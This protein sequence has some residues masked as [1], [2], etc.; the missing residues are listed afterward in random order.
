MKL[1]KSPVVLILSLLASGNVYSTEWVKEIA[2]EGAAKPSLA[3]GADNQPRIAFM[4]EAMPGFVGFAERR[5][6]MWVAQQVASGYFYGPLDL[7]MRG[8]SPIINY[9]DHD[10]EDQVVAIRDE[11]GWSLNP[12]NHPGHDGWDNT[13]AIDSAGRLHTLTT[14]PLDF[15]GPGLEYATLEGGEWRVEEVGTGPIMYAEGLSM[16][17]A[18]DSAPHISYHNTLERSLYYG[19]RLEGGWQLTRVDSGP[20]AGMFSSI[21]LATD[22]TPHI[23]YVRFTVAGAEI[24]LATLQDGQWRSELV[25][26]LPDLT[27]GF[28]FARNATSLRIDPAGFR[29]VAY[30]GESTINLA[31][32]AEAGWEIEIIDTIANNLGTRFG[33]Q[34]DLERD[35]MGQ[36]HLVTFEVLNVSPLT[37]NILYYRSVP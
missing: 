15:G 32:K 23:S 27:V 5:D 19:T 2:F 3:I 18:G 24:C 35:A 31:R 37:G 12:I 36:W 6:D 25:D 1:R 17:F 28:T 21:A 4:V 7:V 30:S 11:L 20:N 13:V 14:D 33:Q 10:R 26:T 22:G 9:H 34:V 16:T 29:H 8:A